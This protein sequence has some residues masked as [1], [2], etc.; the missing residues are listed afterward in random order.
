MEGRVGSE[1]AIN[2]ADTLPN[3]RCVSG[4][5]LSL[6]LSARGEAPVPGELVFCAVSGYLHM[7]SHSVSSD[8]STRKKSSV[9]RQTYATKK[10]VAIF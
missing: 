1:P 7:H 6:E 9:T 4:A 5:E 2:T 3:I 10:Y 8:D